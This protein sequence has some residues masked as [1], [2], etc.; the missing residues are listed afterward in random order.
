MESKVSQSE[1]M[2][3]GGY[4]GARR[5]PEYELKEL[6]EIGVVWVRGKSDLNY[7]IW[8]ELL[9]EYHYLHSAKL[10]GQQI[11]YLVRSSEVGWIGAMSFSSSAWRVKARDERLGWDE[12]ERRSGLRKVVSNSRF[13][14]VPWLRVKNLA[15]HVM[16]KALKRDRKSVV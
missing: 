5:N 12:E 1:E 2:G 8:K 15:S 16:S 13:L 6:G 9:E 10:Y 4:R 14:I 11:K 3:D 7:S